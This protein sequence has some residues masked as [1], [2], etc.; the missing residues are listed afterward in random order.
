MYAWARFLEVRLLGQRVNAY[1]ILP[2]LTILLPLGW[3]YFH[4]Q[5]MIVPIYSLN[6]RLCGQAFEFL[7]MISKKLYLIL[8]LIYI[9]HIMSKVEY[10]F[11]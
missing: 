8:V 5:I 3:Y 7:Q 9:P 6:E 11:I 1:V 2:D 10:F 4:H